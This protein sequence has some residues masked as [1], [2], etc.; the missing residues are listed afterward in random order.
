MKMLQGRWIATIK[1]IKLKKEK[2]RSKN[3]DVECEGIEIAV[4]CQDKA[5]FCVGQDC[6][7]RLSAKK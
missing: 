1:D 4:C 7:S 5:V 2:K 3:F 6:P